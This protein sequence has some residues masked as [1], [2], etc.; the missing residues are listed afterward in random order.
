MLRK[1]GSI[2]LCVRVNPAVIM[3]YYPLPLIDDVFNSFHVCKVFHTIDLL[4]AYLQL[5][6]AELVKFW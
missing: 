4:N 1:N 6:V 3:D 5:R 2:R